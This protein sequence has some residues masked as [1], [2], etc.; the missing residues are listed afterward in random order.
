MPTTFCAAC[1]H[2]DNEVEVHMSSYTLDVK[3][4]YMFEVLR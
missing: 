2:A 1:T 4:Q 3:V